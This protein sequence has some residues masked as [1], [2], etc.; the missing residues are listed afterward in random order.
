MRDCRENRYEAVIM[1][2]AFLSYYRQMDYV[3]SHISALE[4][5]RIAG[6]DGK[7][8]ALQYSQAKLPQT[9]PL[10][11]QLGSSVSTL[12]TPLHC[13]CSK[14]QKSRPKEG[15]IAHWANA[16]LPPRSICRVSQQCGV[17][18]PELALLQVAN[19]LS[20]AE[21]VGM[22]CEFCGL[23]SIQDSAPHGMFSRSA[24]TNT[25][26][27]QTFAQAAS[28]FYGSQALRCAARYALDGS[29]SPAETAAA[30]LFTLPRMRGGYGLGGAVLNQPTSLSAAGQKVAGVKRLR[31]DIMWPEISTCIE[32][33][34]YDFHH[35]E[36]RIAND[37]RRKNALLLSNMHVITLTKT[38]LGN[39][40]EMDK[41][42][43]HIA[44][45][46]GKRWTL[47]DL[48]KQVNLRCELLGAAS[49][50]RRSQELLRRTGRT[51]NA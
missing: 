3:I 20:F 46:A 27:V 9:L 26:R 21:L 8:V 22:T 7:P 40:Q 6:Q 34:S 48:Q 16:S 41:I 28:G 18:S 36:Q 25:N 2:S 24:L 11:T 47:P 35:S 33:D 44:K 37:A 29:R 14:K 19:S 10:S 30:L 15:V 51:N 50:L 49:T 38:Q 13:L 42:A 31:P 43:K 4:Y 12:S 17:A 5:W 45:K 1:N 32:Y 23:F 39:R